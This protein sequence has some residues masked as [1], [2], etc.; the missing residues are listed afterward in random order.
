[1][2]DEN[3]KPIDPA[4]FVGTGSELDKFKKTLTKEQAEK[5]DYIKE[6]TIK[7]VDALIEYFSER[8]IPSPLAAVSVMVSVIGILLEYE[9]D[10]H[11]KDGGKPIPEGMIDGICEYIKA[12][13][14]CRSH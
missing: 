14:T 11:I 3:K 7:E 12:S 8:N 9:H 4:Y 1:M 2:T 6:H 5:A 13:P 10:K